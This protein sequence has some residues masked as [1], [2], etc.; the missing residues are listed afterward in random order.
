MA[1]RLIQGSTFN[2]IVDAIR[3]KNGSTD[4]YKPSQ[5]APA[6]RSLGAEAP[7]TFDEI[8]DFVKAG[9]VSCI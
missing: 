9:C 3:E 6:I 5:M 4:A 7:F 8:P 1:N 2:S